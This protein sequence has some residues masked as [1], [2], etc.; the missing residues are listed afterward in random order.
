[1]V[2]F[3]C[4]WLGLICCVETQS[5]SQA[6]EGQS[7]PIT[8]KT[9]HIDLN[10]DEYCALMRSCE[11]ELLASSQVFSVFDVDGNGYIDVKEFLLALISLRKP[12]VTDEEEQDAAQLYFSVFDL[13]EDKH[14]CK[15]ELALVVDCLLHDGA[16]HVF[17]DDDTTD[18]I[19][20]MFNSIDLDGN[21]LITF[22]EFK[23]FYDTIL[24]A[25]TVEDD[26]KTS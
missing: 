4:L 20:E 11:L 17:L 21:G 8:P 15:D 25:S 13:D 6:P 22:D 16:G 5:E 12:S 26:E 19:D 14:I 24:K 23:H 2:E 9:S 18:G 10:F 1:M 3:N 7:A